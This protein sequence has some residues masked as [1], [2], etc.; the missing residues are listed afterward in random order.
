MV[1]VELIGLGVS[2]ARVLARS[3]STAVKQ[4]VA[5]NA[6]NGNIFQKIGG[7][8][9]GIEAT[10]QMLPNEAGLVLGFDPHEV[11]S[12]EEVRMRLATMLK[13]NDVSKGGSAYLNE[14]FIA[15]AHVLARGDRK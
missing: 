11:P 14:R 12:P 3:V 10:T 9:F 6:P 8:V 4:A 1:L 13:I 7:A 15:A 2:A 5:L